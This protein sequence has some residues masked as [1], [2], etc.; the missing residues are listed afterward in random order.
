MA[1]YVVGHTISKSEQKVGAS[2]HSNK[3]THTSQLALSHYMTSIAFKGPILYL[4]YMPTGVVALLRPVL[5]CS[6]P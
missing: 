3:Q 5:W 6:T 4:K 1:R 2:E